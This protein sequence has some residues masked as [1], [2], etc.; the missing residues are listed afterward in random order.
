MSPAMN[1]A[2]RTLTSEVESVMETL[3]GLLDRESDAVQASDFNTFRSIQNDKHALLTRYRALMDTLQRQSGA[4][5]TADK[6]IL[7]RLKLAAKKFKVST[8]RNASALEA[9]RNSMQRIVDRI[10]KCARDTVHANRQS[11]TKQGHAHLGS[12]G[13]LSIQVNEVL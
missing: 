12:A 5:K 13:P 4:L 7:D 1:N 3:C 10:V 11:Y 9:G 2:T 8:D 6:A